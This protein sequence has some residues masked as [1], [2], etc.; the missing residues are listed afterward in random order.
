MYVIFQLCKL[1]MA[2]IENVVA[3][4]L[5]HAQW[6][7][8]S[9][10]YWKLGQYSLYQLPKAWQKGAWLSWKTYTSSHVLASV[11]LKA[12]DLEKGMAGTESLSEKIPACLTLAVYVQLG[13]VFVLAVNT[14][15][16]H[17]R[18]VFPQRISGAAE[19]VWGGAPFHLPVGSS[20]SFTR[21]RAEAQLFHWS[22]LAPLQ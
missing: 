17:K 7:N 22:G 6:K 1:E 15:M 11:F 13:R 14:V 3:F 12:L 10:F 4:L 8:S 19:A 21:A 18:P 9:W 20:R 2:A 16:P 5:Y